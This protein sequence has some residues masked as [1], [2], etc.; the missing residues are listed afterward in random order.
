MGKLGK[1]EKIGPVVLL[2]VTE[3]SKE[4]FNFL[5]NT[6]SF[7]VSLRMEGSGQGLLNI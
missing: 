2:V 5:V 3:D 7:S 1:W 6:F 4:L